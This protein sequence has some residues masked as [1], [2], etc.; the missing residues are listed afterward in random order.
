MRRIKDYYNWK[1][2][3]QWKFVVDKKMV[4]LK[5]MSGGQL[6]EK[7]LGQAI[8]LLLQDCFPIAIICNI[9][10]D[11]KEIWATPIWNDVFSFLNMEKKIERNSV[12][13]SFEDMDVHEKRKIMDAQIFSIWLNSGN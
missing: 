4:N 7:E 9:K 13:I 11:K 8:D 12:L 3:E 6:S 2:L 10:N 1:T 5:P